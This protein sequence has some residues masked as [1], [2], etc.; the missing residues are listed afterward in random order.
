M[1]LTK[2]RLPKQEPE[3]RESERDV[4]GGQSDL[5]STADVYQPQVTIVVVAVVYQAYGFYVDQWWDVD[6][7]DLCAA[8]KRPTDWQCGFGSPI[9]VYSPQPPKRRVCAYRSTAVTSAELH[10][11]RHTSF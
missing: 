9:I 8:P 4:K 7:S 2:D 10:V 11:R 1:L 6:R 5:H 3:T